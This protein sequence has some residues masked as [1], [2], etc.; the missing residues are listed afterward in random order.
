MAFTATFIRFQQNKIVGLAASAIIFALI[1]KKKQWTIVFQHLT[2]SCMPF[3][4]PT[5]SAAFASH[6]SI[7]R[8]LEAIVPNIATLDVVRVALAHT[9]AQGIVRKQRV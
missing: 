6:T 1:L 3:C 7:S 8:A 4:V 2:Y 5:S 9:V